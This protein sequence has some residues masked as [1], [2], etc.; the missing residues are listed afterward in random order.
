ME[1]GS[2]V[3]PVEDFS[4]VDFW[5]ESEADV[6]SLT[7]VLSLSTAGSS[8]ADFVGGCC[9]DTCCAKS[10]FTA[11]ETAVR[12]EARSSSVVG[13][14]NSVDLM[15]DL[16][17]VSTSASYAAGESWETSGDATGDISDLV[18]AINPSFLEGN[19][20]DELRNNPNLFNPEPDWQPATHIRLSATTAAFNRA[21][22][23]LG[24][25]AKGLRSLHPEFFRIIDDTIDHSQPVD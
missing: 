20:D 16:L 4:F 14:S 17:D 11:S 12:R 22:S 21:Y 18:V 5:V 2:A 25:A 8:L 23:T 10:N 13:V 6:S 19:W 9:V 1:A 15:A 24:R 7:F 3:K